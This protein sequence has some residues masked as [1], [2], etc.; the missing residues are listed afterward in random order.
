MS[1]IETAVKAK[2]MIVNAPPQIDLFVAISPCCV[3]MMFLLPVYDTNSEGYLL[4]PQSFSLLLQTLL[5][6]LVV[7]LLVLAILLLL[8][9]IAIL[10]SWP[11]SLHSSVAEISTTGQ[12]MPSCGLDMHPHGCTYSQMTYFYNGPLSL[13]IYL[14]VYTRMGSYSLVNS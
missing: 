11:A 6:D 13:S 14:S 7:G 3:Q 4:P 12:H 1:I 9:L 10:P 8:Q 5:L 2:Y